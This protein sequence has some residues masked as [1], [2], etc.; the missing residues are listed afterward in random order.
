MSPYCPGKH[1]RLHTHKK[2][3][4]R[5]SV[6]QNSVICITIWAIALTKYITYNL[7]PQVDMSFATF[8]WGFYVRYV[9][10]RPRMIHDAGGRSVGKWS[11]SQ[12]KP[13][14]TARRPIVAFG[15]F[16]SELFL[17]FGEAGENVYKKQQ[18]YLTTDWTQRISYLRSCHDHR[19]QTHY[20]SKNKVQSYLI[21]LYLGAIRLWQRVR[22]DD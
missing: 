1:P 7:K 19:K 11:D 8:V 12:D 20:Q 15:V 3:T 2:K 4:L 14:N 16:R 17:V 13:C 10:Y 18:L 22:L 21:Y 6:T 5:V 9:R